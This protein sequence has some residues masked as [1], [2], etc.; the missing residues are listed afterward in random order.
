[1]KKISILIPAY[2]EQEVLEQLYQRIGKLAND[3]KSYEFEFMFV[4]DGSRDKTLEIIKSYA[5]SDNRVAYVNLSRNFGKEIAMIAGLDHVTGD[6][7]VIIDADLQDP[8]ELIPKM[9]K[10]W[11]QGF[12]DVYAKRNSREG[13]SWLKKVSSRWF[14]KILQKTTRIPIQTDTG[15]FRLLDKKCVDALKEIRESQ[16]YT[17][18][19]FSWIGFNKKEIT[20]DRDPRAAGE[21]KWNYSKLFNFA[22]DGITSFTT[23]P[24]RISTILGFVV[25]FVA[26][27]YIVVLIIKTTL[28]G[29]PVAGYPSLMAVILFLGGLQLLS[30]GVIGEYIGRI[31][32]ETKQRP[33]YFVEEYH[34]ERNVKKQR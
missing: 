4:N 2:N 15:D 20:Y 16:R 30:L 18:G 19:M 28:F 26:F 31:F 1:M 14:Y 13:E 25:S 32:N 21:T 11:E 27:I 29:D 3:N 22:I 34:N 10:F 9:L 33:L 12:D 7:T 5:K 8:P 6:A 17:K 23:A 24:L